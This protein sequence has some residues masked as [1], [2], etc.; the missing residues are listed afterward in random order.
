MLVGFNKFP[1]GSL[2]HPP[3]MAGMICGRL[4]LV[5]CLLCDAAGFRVSAARPSRRET[6]GLGAAAVFAATPLAV[7]AADVND[8]SRLKKGQESVQYLLDNWDRETIDP[9]SGEDSPDRVRYFVGLRTTDHPLFQVDKLLSKAQQNLPDDVDFDRWIDAVE[10]LNS[11]IA[12]VNELAY[13]A[14]FG[15]Y[16]PGGGKEQV[17]KYLLLAKEEVQAARDSLKVMVELFKL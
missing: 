8:L 3:C 10:G 13:T 14:S 17:R 6:L 4:L 2:S 15:E 1:G 11:H 16:N 9:N 5:C 12:K 7:C